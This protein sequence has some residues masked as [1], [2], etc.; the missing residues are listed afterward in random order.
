MEARPGNIHRGGLNG[1]VSRLEVMSLHTYHA[2]AGKK[3]PLLRFFFFPDGDFRTQIN[4]RMQE[5]AECLRQSGQL[6]VH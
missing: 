4:S 5:V 3:Q 6:N 2:S 1:A